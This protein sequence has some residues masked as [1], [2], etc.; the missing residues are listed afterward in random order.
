MLNNS[1]RGGV[2]ACVTKNYQ[3]MKKLI[4]TI[5]VSAFA[6]FG[7]A[8]ESDARPYGGGY[9]HQAPQSQIY[10]SGYR[11]GRPVYTQ[12]IFVGYDRYHRPIYQYRTVSAPRRHY[13]GHH[14]QCETGYGGGYGGHRRSGSSISFNFSR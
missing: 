12:K 9:G 13:G 6:F 2:K 10:V 1:E 7:T 3:A 8:V 14:N 4:T 5:A 11:Y